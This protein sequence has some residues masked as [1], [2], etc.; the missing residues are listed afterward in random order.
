MALS[1]SS[2][3]L[4]FS[5]ISLPS[6]SKPPSKSSRRS[7]S[8][9]L[10]S[11]CSA[12]AEPTPDWSA[13][14]SAPRMRRVST[15][16]SRLASRVLRSTPR[17]SAAFL[18]P[19]SRSS[20]CNSDMSRRWCMSRTLL[21]FSTTSFFGSMSPP[22]FAGL[23]PR[24]RPRTRPGSS[25]AAPCGPPVGGNAGFRPDSAPLSCGP[26]APLFAERGRPGDLSPSVHNFCAISA[27]FVPVSASPCPH[28]Q[29]RHRLRFLVQPPYCTGGCLLPRTSKGATFLSSLLGSFHRHFVRSHSLAS[30]AIR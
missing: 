13:F 14:S 21:P 3:A 28:R 5:R 9:S 22:P 7:A 12:A 4:L 29:L 19:L 23:S 17:T 8:W 25:R 26:A 6:S 27:P 20:S 2:L 24:S 16:S 11:R 10:R 1:L 18:R 15:P 30:A